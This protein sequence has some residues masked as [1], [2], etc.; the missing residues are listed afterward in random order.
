[1]VFLILPVVA[2]VA[3]ACVVFVLHRHVVREYGQLNLSDE[4]L[5][6]VRTAILDYVDFNTDFPGQFIPLGKFWRQ[7]DRKY[8]FVERFEVLDPLIRQRT[9]I[10]QLSSGSITQRYDRFLYHTYK[11]APASFAMR[12]ALLEERRRAKP[13]MTKVKKTVFTAKGGSSIAYTSGKGSAQ[14]TVSDNL[15]VKGLTSEHISALAGA[16]RSDAEQAQSVNVKNMAVELAD[17]CDSAV[18]E[19]ADAPSRVKLWSR[20]TALV[21]LAATGMDATAQLINSIKGLL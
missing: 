2:L 13:T 19:A 17:E 6:H 9:M 21:A 16:L 15:T 20:A 7:L 11:I 10:P 1:V 4:E 3:L 8:S 5:E 14:S 12:P 18:A